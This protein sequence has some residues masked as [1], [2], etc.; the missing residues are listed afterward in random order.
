MEITNIVLV[1]PVC[2]TIHESAIIEKPF[3]IDISLRF[4][5]CPVKGIIYLPADQQELLDE[6][7]DED[8]ISCQ[9]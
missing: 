9:Y 2:H 7:T 1:C 3:T 6:L 8:Q 5:T 4:Q